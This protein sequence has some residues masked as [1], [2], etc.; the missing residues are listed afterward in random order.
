V[1]VVVF[2]QVAPCAVLTC[3]MNLLSR[4]FMSR[5]KIQKLASILTLCARKLDEVATF[6][7]SVFGV[8]LSYLGRYTDYPDRYL[9]CV[10]SVPLGMVT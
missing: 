5:L 2:L 7:I 1:E 10:L 6:L 8:A 4:I 3:Q 9:L